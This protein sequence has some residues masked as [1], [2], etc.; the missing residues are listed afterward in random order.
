AAAQLRGLLQARSRRDSQQIAHDARR[1]RPEE[2]IRRPRCDRAEGQAY[3]L[4][5]SPPLALGIH[6]KAVG[7]AHGSRR[8]RARTGTALQLE[9]NQGTA[10]T[11]TISIT[12][13]GCASAA[14]PITSE[15]GGLL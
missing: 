7:A 5:V 3:R 2:A 15:G 1:R 9:P 10:A 6:R 4:S 13:S 14:T 8:T 11:A 12:R